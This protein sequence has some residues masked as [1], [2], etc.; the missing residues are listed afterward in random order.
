MIVKSINREYNILPEGEYDKF[1]EGV[2]KDY[3]LGIGEAKDVSKLVQFL[4]S[5]D[6]KWMT[7]SNVIIDGG[8]SINI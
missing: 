6:A 3:L 4:L 2:G 8:R 5:D 1:L 7:G